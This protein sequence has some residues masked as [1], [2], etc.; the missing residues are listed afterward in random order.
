MKR[1]TED[2]TETSAVIRFIR[3]LR[4]LFLRDRAGGRTRIVARTVILV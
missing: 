1:M 2:Q 4:V 3:V